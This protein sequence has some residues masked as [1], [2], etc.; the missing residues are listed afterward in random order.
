MAQVAIVNQTTIVS[1]ADGLT[2]TTALNMVLPQFCM[3]WS[4]SRYTCVYVGR[5]KTTTIPLKIFLKDDADQPGVLAYHDEINDIPYGNV[6]IKTVLKNNGV[7]LYS[8]NPVVPTFSEAVCHELFEMLIDPNC[9]TWAMLSD[10]NTLYAYEVCDPVQSN[11]VTVQV[12]TGTTTTG[13][14]PNVKVVPV[15]TSVGLS[16]WV[17]PNWFDPQKKRGPYNHNN[18]L[19]SPLTIDKNGYVISLKDGVCKPIWGSMVTPDRQRAF[20]AKQRVL[21]HLTT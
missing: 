14:V 20:A 5:G 13:K 8:P 11:P 9:N 2:I 6:F 16:D 4:L 21:R 17:L 7:L 18:T 15:Y 1:D 3:D 12:Q 19:N 10:Y